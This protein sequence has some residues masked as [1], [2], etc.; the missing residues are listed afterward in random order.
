MATS[1][2]ELL[3]QIGT[4]KDK[5][6][7]L[8]EQ[9]TTRLQQIA[10]KRAN[11]VMYPN[12]SADLE[13]INVT[14]NLF[15]SKEY[16]PF[17]PIAFLYSKGQQQPGA[18]LFGGTLAYSIQLTGAF[19]GD[20]YVNI[21]FS[22]CSSADA[23]L[24]NSV[25]RDMVRYC[26]L[27]AARLIKIANLYFKG[28]VQSSYNRM[29]FIHHLHH[30]L[31]KERLPTYYK[32]LGQEELIEGEVNPRPGFTEYKSVRKYGFG[33]QTFKVTQPPLSMFYP[34][35]YWFNT[36]SSEV[37]VNRVSDTISLKFELDLVTNIVEKLGSGTNGPVTYPTIDA[38]TLYYKDIYV[39]REIHEMYIRRKGMQVLST[40]RYQEFDIIKS[41]D[42]QLLSS[43]DW[44]IERM[45]LSYIPVANESNYQNW[46]KGLVLTQQNVPELA[47]S[48]DT[49]LL[50]PATYFVDTVLASAYTEAL[51][52]QLLD[53]RTATIIYYDTFPA[54]FFTHYGT[55]FDEDLQWASIG[56]CVV[57]F[58]YKPN[59]KNVYSGYTSTTNNTD[60]SIRYASN[61]FSSIN[62]G[63]L[64]ISTRVLD[65]LMIDVK[66]LEIRYNN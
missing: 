40:W 10:A 6:F 37:L 25:P 57:H 1:N 4:A 33:P 26:A 16:R 18:M 53:I 13:D 7:T 3:L 45:F 28:V 47:V 39:P 31:P 42:T 49:T 48:L 38:A 14:H 24:P 2:V 27:P 58:D 55:N 20:V 34:L 43:S 36:N 56:S 41:T 12:G 21:V 63:K 11:S 22:Q 23:A 52:I 65:T 8:Y 35:I 50:P 15:V 32:M 29:N 9:L 19:I 51:P 59:Q 64:Y 44:P 61:Y 5:V 54:D 46:Y 62:P 17:I 30:E 66:L 60:F